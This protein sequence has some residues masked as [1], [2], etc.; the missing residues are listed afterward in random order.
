M[1]KVVWFDKPCEMARV[2]KNA[3]G[4]GLDVR[5]SSFNGKPLV[6]RDLPSPHLDILVTEDS[7]GELWVHGLQA[8]GEPHPLVSAIQKH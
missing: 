8:Y 5:C 7:A 2:I 4:L 1:E 3:Y 6:L